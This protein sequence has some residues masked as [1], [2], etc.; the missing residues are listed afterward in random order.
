MKTAKKLNYRDYEII[1]YPLLTE[2]SNMM[3]SNAQYFFAVRK[4][5]SKP[6]IKSAIENLFHVKVQAVN[7]LIKK[8]KTRIFKGRRGVQSDVKKAMVCLEAGQKI[9]FSTGV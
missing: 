6:E 9:D 5:A 7:T 1:L 3:T 2:K 8:G 4:D